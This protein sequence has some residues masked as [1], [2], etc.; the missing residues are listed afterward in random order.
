MEDAHRFANM[1]GGHGWAT[2]S[3]DKQ[4]TKEGIVYTLRCTCNVLLRDAR[5]ALLHSASL[6]PHPPTLQVWES[7]ESNVKQRRISQGFGAGSGSSGVLRTES[8]CPAMAWVTYVPTADLPYQLT[9]MFEHT[10]PAPLEVDDS[11]HPVAVLDK[12]TV[13]RL[14]DS[15]KGDVDAAYAQLVAEMELSR[16]NSRP[17]AAGAFSRMAARWCGSTAPFKRVPLVT[18]DASAPWELTPTKRCCF[19]R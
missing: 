15:H 4:R 12:D 8:G 5:A 16:P 13:A 19:A 7:N 9:V 18:R 10:H 17:P 6:S 11:A 3:T 2:S 1:K 14:L